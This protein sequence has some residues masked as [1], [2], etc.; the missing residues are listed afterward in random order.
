MKVKDAI[1]KLEE[2][3]PDATLRVDPPY[4]PV[5]GLYVRDNSDVVEISH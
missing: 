1:A 3:D 5:I 4:S 2:C